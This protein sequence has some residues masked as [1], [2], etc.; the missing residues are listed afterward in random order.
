MIQTIF[1]RKMI[2]LY[3][4]Q[5]NEKEELIKINI[6]EIFDQKLEIIEENRKYFVFNF[7][8]NAK[9]EDVIELRENTFIKECMNNNTDDAMND[10]Y[11]AYDCTS[12]FLEFDIMNE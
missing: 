3:C 9:I 2:M 1:F 11:F 7:E 5:R 4:P 8:I 10:K 12:E 6:K